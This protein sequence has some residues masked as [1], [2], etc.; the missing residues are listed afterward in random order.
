MAKTLIYLVAA[1]NGTFTSY[2]RD[3]RAPTKMSAFADPFRAA[4]AEVD[5][6]VFIPGHFFGENDPLPMSPLAA[7]EIAARVDALKLK[8]ASVSVDEYTGGLWVWMR[9]TFFAFE[10]EP[11]KNIEALM[12][13]F[14]RHA[15]RAVVGERPVVALELE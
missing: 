8:C 4:R 9:D 3:P 13:I 7:D 1:D 10:R 11:R 15:D 2:A 5:G 14:S 6:E 12:T